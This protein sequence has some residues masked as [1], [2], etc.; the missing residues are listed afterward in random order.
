M[1]WLMAAQTISK[2]RTWNWK[3]AAIFRL[4]ALHNMFLCFTTVGLLWI[5]PILAS[6]AVR[7]FVVVIK[8]KFWFT[9]WLI[10]R[11][12]ISLA[13]TSSV[14][15]VLIEREMCQIF[16]V[17]VSH[18]NSFVWLISLPLS[19]RFEICATTFSRPNATKCPRCKRRTAVNWCGLCIALNREWNA[20]GWSDTDYE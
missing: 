3:Y 17:S 5:E 12:F 18:R 14:V 9:H 1:V 11:L 8:Q 10:C 13:S 7:L 4:S 6:L 20:N 16:S 2:I 15:H 19:S